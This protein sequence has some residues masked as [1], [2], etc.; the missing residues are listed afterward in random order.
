M[1]Q[2]LAGITLNET[3]IAYFI[4]MS[5]A[6]WYSSC[7]RSFM[8]ITVKDIAEEAGVSLGT[9][10]RVLNEH[11]RVSEENRRR[12]SRVI[13]QLG[14]TRLRRRSHQSLGAGLRNK[15]LML[16]TLGMHRTLAQLP[17]V[18]QVMHGIQDMV[19]KSRASLLLADCPDPTNALRTVGLSPVD[20]VLIKGAMQGDLVA[21]LEPGFVDWL[22]N[23]PCVWF[24]GR[25]TGLPGDVVG[26]NDWDVGVLAANHLVKRGHTRLA[27]LSPKP[28]HALFERRQAGFRAQARKL[29]AA[30][31]SYVGT[32]RK[33]TLPLEPANDLDIVQRLLDKILNAEAPVTAVFVPADSIAI[34]VYRALAERHL[35]PGNDI[36]VISVNNELSIVSALY[37][38]L[39]TIDVQAEEIGRL[40]VQQLADRLSSPTMNASMEQNLDPML[41]PGQSVSDLRQ[42]TEA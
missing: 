24:M 4:E 10:S 11:P 2:R 5:D 18:A 3:T 40:A 30:M 38:S 28:G 37:P 33:W 9:V 42:A 41:V 39:T 7:D 22:K 12:V 19:T 16:V 32:T 25:P 35:K 8:S 14:Y 21:A 36:A 6:A 34:L 29:G 1:G 23:H 13:K 31:T 15:T 27:F 17:V 20:G 26:T